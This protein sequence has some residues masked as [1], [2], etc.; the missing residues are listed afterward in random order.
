M[1]LLTACAHTQKEPEDKDEI[2][3]KV[4]NSQDYILA[5]QYHNAQNYDKALVYYQKVLDML[6]N[7]MQAESST[8][9]WIK[10]QMARCYVL[11]EEYE[12][13]LPYMQEAK[14]G[15]EKTGGNYQ[16][17]TIYHEEGLYYAAIGQD[18]KALEC[19]QKAIE[20]AEGEQLILVYTS[21]AL[22]YEV[23]HEEQEALHYYNLAIE[24]G[25]RQNG[26]EGLVNVYYTKGLYLAANDQME[27]AKEHIEKGMEYAEYVWGKNDIKV[28]EGYKNLSKV[29]VRERDFES[30]YT[31]CRKALDIYKNQ[32]NAYSYDREIAGLYSNM[33][34]LNRKLGDYATALELYQRSYD[35]VKE[36]KEE[37]DFLEF[38]EETLGINIKNLYDSTVDD[39]R[40][41]EAWFNENFENK[42]VQ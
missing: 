1:S 41:Y 6:D 28:A 38:Y 8:G 16:L 17:F 27:A 11:E 34:V 3:R 7:E 15:F 13:A 22:S 26:R 9:Y 10:G 23:L 25:E 19:Y 35:I 40:G 18:N 32:S 4:M 5:V 14:E 24:E 21:M 36:R 12:K 42:S 30:A 31:Y 2:E 20:Y 29:N 37:Q 33:G 39:E